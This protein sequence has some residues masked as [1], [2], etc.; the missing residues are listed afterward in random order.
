M[1]F[2]RRIVPLFGIFSNILM[3]ID[4][5]LGLGPPGN[6]YFSLVLNV[7]FHYAKIPLV[8]KRFSFSL[9]QFLYVLLY[10]VY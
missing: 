4:L 8:L 2:E 10:V 3:Q 5:V 9:S 6:F 7:Q 1:I